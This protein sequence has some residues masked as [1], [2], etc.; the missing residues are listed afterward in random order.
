MTS[1]RYTT[2][3]HLC[4]ILHTSRVRL[5]TS[6][7]VSTE[8][9]AMTSFPVEIQ[10]P[11]SIP[12][13]QLQGH[14]RRRTHFLRRATSRF[15]RCHCRPAATASVVPPSVLART[16]TVQAALAVTVTL[17]PLLP[18][19]SRPGAPTSTRG[20]CR[21]RR[22]GTRAW[23]PTTALTAAALA[24]TTTATVTPLR[25]P[26]VPLYPRATAAAAAATASAA[27]ESAALL[28]RVC[29]STPAAALCTA[30]A[31]R[32]WLPH[33]WQQHEEQCRRR[34]LYQRLSALAAQVRPATSSNTSSH[35]ISNP[36][37]RARSPILSRRR[38]TKPSTIHLYNSN[39]TSSSNSIIINHSNT[40]STNSTNK[41]SSSISSCRRR[42]ATATARPI[43]AAAARWKN[44]G[45]DGWPGTA[46][47]RGSRGSA[48]SSTWKCW[49]KKWR[50]W[51]GKWR[52]CG[53]RICW[54]PSRPCRSCATSTCGVWKA[55]PT[56]SAR[57]S[58]CR[59]LDEGHMRV[60]CTGS[61]SVCVCFVLFLFSV[62][63]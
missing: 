61:L 2:R 47:R 59:G 42:T 57:W 55:W 40:S 44:G 10:L 3:R 15:S 22:R 23:L 56:A 17:S 8:V 11:A 16:A 24:A 46:S 50:R 21:R 29:S 7:V 5:P 38:P 18:S 1:M 54:A 26:F 20:R 19:F 13:R 52:G 12:T 60:E 49:K 37:R 63:R 25:K 36:N 45:L 43:S 31:A 28:A 14:I 35:T 53:G 33:L 30:T 58:C 48:R 62:A 51:W 6:T 27:V 32:T 4:Q 39:C 9:Q 34:R 41:H